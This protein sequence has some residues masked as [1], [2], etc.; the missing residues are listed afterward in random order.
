MAISTTAWLFSALKGLLRWW[1]AA[2]LAVFGCSAHA[3]WPERPVMLVVPFAPGS[4]PDAA[5]RAVAA[6]LAQRLRQPVVVENKPGAS[7]RIGTQQVARAKGDGYTLLFGNMD[8]HAVNP[9]V[10]RNIAYDAEKDFAPVSL[11]ATGGVVLVASPQSAFANGR[12]LIQAARA[13]P[14]KISYGSWG[15]GSVAHLWGLLLEQTGGITMLH[16]PY[17]GTPQAVNALMSNQIDLMFV[18]VPLALAS[19]PQNRMKIIG[20]T[21]REPL[22]QHPQIVPLAQQ[23]FAGY[24]GA[25]WLAIY[26][27]QGT[28][29]DVLARLNKEV[30][31]V[32]TEPDVVQAIRGLGLEPAGG[33]AQLLRK[34][35]ADSREQWAQLIARHHIQID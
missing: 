1:P 19:V 29:A 32:L 30:N 2:M 5:A 23:G 6:G 11:V 16:V 18:T 27:A 14:G 22:P 31:Q 34:A 8:T 21:L 3:A 17:Q 28:P 26:A 7:G 9:L 12:E 15:Q 24:H 20:G 33:D 35:M 25:T 4:P 10:Y 13:A